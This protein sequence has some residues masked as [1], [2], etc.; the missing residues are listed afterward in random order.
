M[1]TGEVYGDA[2]RSENIEWAAKVIQEKPV[3]KTRYLIICNDVQTEYAEQLAGN[4]YNVISLDDAKNGLASAIAGNPCV[5]WPD[6]RTL[7]TARMYAKE[8]AEFGE[9]KLID[10]SRGLMWTPQEFIEAN[11]NY[12]YFV[13]W[14]TGKAD[15]SK[16]LLVTINAPSPGGSSESGSPLDSV[17]YP[18]DEGAPFED[19]P[20]E[21][22]EEASSAPL[23]AEAAYLPYRS[24]DDAVGG[25]EW[26]EP[27]NFWVTPEPPIMRPE[28][29]PNALSEYAMYEGETIGVDPGILGLD[30]LGFCCGAISDGIKLQVKADNPRW[31][32][33]ARLWICI[34]GNSASKKSPALKEID[35]PAWALERSMRERS[36]SEVE[37]YD[38]AMLVYEQQRKNYASEAA[39]GGAAIA[40]EKPLR[41]N[42]NRLL[43][44]DTT[45]EALADVLLDQGDRGVL[46][47]ADE[48]V[49]IFGSMNQYKQSGNDRQFFLQ[50]FDGGPF[51]VDRKGRDTLIGNLGVTILGGTQPSALRKIAH[52]LNLEADGLMQ[53]FVPYIAANAVEDQERGSHHAGHARYADILERLMELQHTGPVKF[54]GEAQ[55]IRRDFSKW[56]WEAA[57]GEWCGDALRSHISKYDTF[58]A[59]TCLAY[60]C[61]DTADKHDAWIPDEIPEEIAEQVSSLYRH[62]LFHH[63]GHFY[64]QTLSTTSDLIHHVREIASK[65]LAFE[66]VEISPTLLAQKMWAWRNLKDWEKRSIFTVLAEAGWT[67]TDDKRGYVPGVPI[68]YV[69]NPRLRS[70]FAEQAAIERDI[71]NEKSERLTASNLKPRGKARRDD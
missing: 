66:W 8:L 31:L 18:P 40:P 17:P 67:R 2:R 5:L 23:S 62:C 47:L 46:L 42:R 50:A 37:R 9:V 60:H 61:I 65:I 11:W 28:W 58:F 24:H 25:S 22:Y 16:N 35:G 30:L 56:A 13:Q 36:I 71:Q 26:P 63:A 33:S 43:V 68:K 38:N 14:V 45:R 48:I 3:E 70:M 15:N 1:T 54:S 27:A 7:A 64:S 21:A 4:V 52:Q 29:L 10:V 19:I 53:R 20:V 44:G 55:A 41:P 12:D 32:Q 34:V 39:K 6:S 49:S 69:V 59:R 51:V 57:K